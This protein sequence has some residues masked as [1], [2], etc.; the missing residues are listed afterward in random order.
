MF[1]RLV[2]VHIKPEQLANAEQHYD[3]LVIPALSKTR[4]SLYCSFL[5]STQHA[6]MCMSL[7]L[8]DNRQHAEEYEAGG[9]FQRLMKSASPFFAA[10]SEWRIHLSEDTNVEY[11]PVAEQ[12]EVKAYNL[13]G[14]DV[15]KTFTQGAIG[16]LFVRIVS[17]QI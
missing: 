4:G 10:T 6:E 16:S 1:L 12:P 13:A 17:P 5:Q 8:W 3:E 9:T 7:T 11:E 15:A 14:S 2:Q